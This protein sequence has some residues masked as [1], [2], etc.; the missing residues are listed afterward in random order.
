MERVLVE[1]VACTADDAVRAEAVGADRIELVS[2]ISEG[3]LTPSIGALAETKARCRLPIMAML[4]PRGGGFVYT[5][6][7]FQ[8]ILRDAEALL[9]AGADGLVVGILADR[10]IDEDRIRRFVQI[11][12]VQPVTFHRAF[13][14][15]PD[16]FAAL[17]RL[18]DLGV[19]RVLTRGGL[20]SINPARLRQYAE[21]AQVIQLLACGGIRAANVSSVVAE[22]GAAQIHLG[23]FIPKRDPVF[24]NPADPTLVEHLTLDDEEVRRVVRAIQPV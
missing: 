10:G 8:T 14:L 17:S 18:R 19:A 20:S 6:A 7:E 2:A 9:A 12:G 4:R 24:Y 22:S 5:D 23:P 16:P 1:V 11:A 15:L 13:D 3:G 21:H